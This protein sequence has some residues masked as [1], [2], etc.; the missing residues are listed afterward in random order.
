MD[1][2]GS[3]LRVFDQFL[4]ESDFFLRKYEKSRDGED[5]NSE[6]L[7]LKDETGNENATETEMK[8]I[9]FPK[10]A[11]GLKPSGGTRRKKSNPNLKVEILENGKNLPLTVRIDFN[12]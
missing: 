3:N 7:D 10:L 4:A 5:H 6:E 1:Q 2:Y 11:L 9:H 8:K 12:M